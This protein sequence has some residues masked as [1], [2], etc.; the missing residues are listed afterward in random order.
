MAFAKRIS[1][2]ILVACAD[3]NVIINVAQCIQ[4]TRSQTRITAGLFYASFI[5]WAFGVD[6]AFG[7]TVRWHSDELT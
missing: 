5:A 2:I 6:E 4:T 7:T 3:G 1:Y